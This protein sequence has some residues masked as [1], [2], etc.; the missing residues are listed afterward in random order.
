MVNIPP[1]G[2]CDYKINKWPLGPLTA[3]IF[4]LRIDSIYSLGPGLDLDDLTMITDSSVS[5]LPSSVASTTSLP[6]GDDVTVLPLEAR[7][8]P[9]L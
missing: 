4:L 7:A 2:E 8:L 5:G 9:F 1:G 6:L 3:P